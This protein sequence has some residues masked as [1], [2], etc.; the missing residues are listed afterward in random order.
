MRNEDGL[1]RFERI[2][3]PAFILLLI[4]AAILI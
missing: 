2:A 4:L 1:T 3:M